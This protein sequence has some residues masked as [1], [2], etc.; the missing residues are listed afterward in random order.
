MWIDNPLHSNL[1]TLGEVTLIIKL[2][3]QGVA[4]GLFSKHRTECDTTVDLIEYFSP[5]QLVTDWCSGCL[6]CCCCVFTGVHLNERLHALLLFHSPGWQ[7][8][9]DGGE[10][11]GSWGGGRGPTEGRGHCGYARWGIFY[12]DILSVVYFLNGNCSL[13]SLKLAHYNGSVIEC[14]IV[15]LCVIHLSELLLIF[16]LYRMVAQHW[17]W[18]VLRVMRWWWRPYWRQGPL[19]ICKLRCYSYWKFISCLVSKY[20]RHSK[21]ASLNYNARL[22]NTFHKSR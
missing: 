7:N 2:V 3:V 22:E 8:S 20:H 17:W 12:T 13:T 5:N 9:T 16:S 11:T 4:M 14:V 19:W 18:R 15:S 1:C 6:W 21:F 10:W